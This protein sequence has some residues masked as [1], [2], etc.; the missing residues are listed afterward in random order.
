MGRPII[1]LGEHYL[2]WSTVVD[3]PVTFGMLLPEFRD[4]YQDKYGE[5]GMRDLDGRLE[6]VE[7]KGSSYHRIDE[8]V[9]SVIAGNR[10]GPGESQLTRD[11]I[12]LAYCLGT[13]IRDGWLPQ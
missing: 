8:D 12:Y 5:H 10:A 1:K 2:E 7:A 3:A 11:E 4:Y 9:E 13:P 6:R